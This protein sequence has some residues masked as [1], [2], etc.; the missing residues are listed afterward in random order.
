MKCLLKCTDFGSKFEIRWEI[1]FFCH[2]FWSVNVSEVVQP[3]CLNITFN[4]YLKVKICHFF[5]KKRLWVSSAVY[6][7]WRKENQFSKQI[8]ENIEITSTFTT[9]YGLKNDF[10]RFESITWKPPIFIKRATVDA[11]TINR[12]IHKHFQAQIMCY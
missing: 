5:W 7:F 6:N 10:F 12:L 2:Y 11:K 3:R 9:W 1:I 8:S 4:T